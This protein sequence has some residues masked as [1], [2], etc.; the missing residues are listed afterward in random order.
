[1]PELLTERTRLHRKASRGSHDR[2]AIEAILDEAL[3]CHVGFASDAGP[4]VLPTAQ[5]RIGDQLY[6]HGAAQNAMLGALARG[7]PACMTITL[8]DG[9]VLS[10]TAFHHSVN[11]RSVVVFGRARRV[12]DPVEKRAA[13]AALI[14]KIEPGRSARC[15]PPSDKEMNATLMIALA[16]TEASAKSRSGPPLPDD[17]DDAKLPY[18]AGVIPLVTSRGAPI[19][20]L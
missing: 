14:D 1:M 3:I 10:R 12:D 16:I 9:L 2:A 11:Y 15:R 20:A 18:W 19:A 13:F 17:D 6:V 8:L 4:V 5:V 7:A